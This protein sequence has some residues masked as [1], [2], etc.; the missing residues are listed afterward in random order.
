M[1]LV[2][3]S[4]VSVKNGRLINKYELIERRLTPK[5]I[6]STLYYFNREKDAELYRLYLLQKEGERQLNATIH[7]ERTHN[8]E[9]KELEAFKETIDW[10]EL[11][12]K[13]KNIKVDI[14]K[15]FVE[16][17]GKK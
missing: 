2:G 4:F 5:G 7:S 10:N 16:I 1:E 13:I 17:R 9:R 6:F 15:A 14:E 3:P 12:A 8:W 11:P